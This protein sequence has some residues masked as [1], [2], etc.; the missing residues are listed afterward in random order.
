MKTK[1]KVKVLTEGCMPT[2]TEK[3]DWIDLRSAI[4]YTFLPAQADV[5]ATKK[6]MNNSTIQFRN[7][8]MQAY[9]I[10]LGVAMELPDGYEA[11]LASRSSGPTKMKLMIPAGIGIIDNTYCSDDDEW[12][13]V[14]SPMQ[15]TNIHAGD[16]VCQFRIQLSQKATLW[17]KI[18]WFFS[19][20]IELVE[21]ETLNNETRGGLG[22]T[23]IN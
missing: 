3:G 15:A 18:K 13:Y 9:P 22:S 5:A 14:C 12:Y 1:I 21:V 17:Q 10:P 11:I 7:V 16:R 6:K 23:G 4:D 2:I 8:N 20:G 19:N